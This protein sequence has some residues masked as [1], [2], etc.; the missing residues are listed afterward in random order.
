MDKE[1]TKGPKL[2]GLTGVYCAGKNHIAAVLAERGLPVLDVDK[3]G[4]EAIETEKEAIL[5]LFGRD[6]LGPEGR[7]NRRLLGEKV[8]GKPE[9]LA[10]LQAIVHPA[11]NSMTEKWIAAQGGK[12]CVIN[13]ALLHQSSIFNRLDC[14]ILVRAPFLTRLL[15]A[16]KRDHLPWSSILKR[17]GSQKKFTSQYLMGKADI[18]R[19]DNRGYSKI[20]SRFFR[21]NLESR[22]DHILSGEGIQ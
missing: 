21:R 4:H 6:I 13:A 5:N 19:V 17:F 18:Y 7:I 20:G 10:A 15:R 16:R 11:A 12:P 9:E 3:L 1:H 8:F 22:I 2:I 14:I